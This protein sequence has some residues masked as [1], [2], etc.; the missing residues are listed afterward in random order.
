MAIHSGYTLW[1]GR[2]CQEPRMQ[3]RQGGLHDRQ[4]SERVRAACDRGTRSVGMLEFEQYDSAQRG[5]ERLGLKIGVVTDVGR[6]DDKNFNQYSYEGAKTAATTLGTTAEYVVPKDAS[7]YTKD[8]QGF[9]DQ[10]YNIIVTVGFNLGDA[11][12]KAAKANPDIWFIAV[13]VA[14]CVDRRPAPRTARSPARAMPPSCCR[15]LIG[16]QFQEDQAG[17]LAG[18]V[19]A[20]RQQGRQDRPARRHQQQPGGRPL[21]QGYQLGAASYKSTT[22]VI[23]RLL[24]DRRPGQGLRR[25]GLRQDLQRPVHQAEGR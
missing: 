18:I 25:P 9:V 12:I 2:F 7:D 24:L 17:Y 14:P 22:K 10:K 19:A 1:I 15:K 6:V 8:I 23:T 5:A 20:C 13:D 3:C 4:A 11:T 21:L 16:I